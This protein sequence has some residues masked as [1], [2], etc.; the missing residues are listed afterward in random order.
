MDPVKINFAESATALAVYKKQQRRRYNCVAKFM[1]LPL[2]PLLLHGESTSAQ[3]VGDRAKLFFSG[4]D[5]VFFDSGLH[6]IIIS[7]S[8]SAE[9]ERV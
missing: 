2:S 4:L 6:M 9:G 7:A 3:S 8:C 5:L 1:S